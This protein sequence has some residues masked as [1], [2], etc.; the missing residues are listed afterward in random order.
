MRELGRWSEINREAEIGVLDAGLDFRLP[1]YRRAV[2]KRFYDFHTRYRSHPGGVYYLMPEIS[3]RA[4]FTEE[5]KLWFAFINGNTQNPVTSWIIFNQ[6]PN[7]SKAGDILGWFNKEWHRLQFDTDRRYQK[8]LFPMSS[9]KYMHL[10]RGNQEEYFH[11]LYA[12]ATGKA[13]FN[14][15]WQT[16]T[17]KFLGFGRLAAYSYTE[18]L[19]VMGLPVECDSLMLWDM[20]GS[21]SHRNG[22][23][24]VLGRDDLDWHASN[25][26]FNGEYGNDLL[27]W[28]ESEADVL[29]SEC[30]SFSKT[31]EN[32][33]VHEM[34]YH[35]F[36]S[37]LC[38]YKSWH[39]P[40]RRYPNV[41]N[42]MLHERIVHAQY[43]WPDMDLSMFWD[44]RKDVLP[45][46]LRLEDN[47]RDCG[48]HPS[49]QN[50]YLNTGEVIMMDTEF[51]EF[52]N[53]WMAA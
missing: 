10:T 6:F 7:V 37:A 28:L 4:G 18:Y 16:V 29:L 38:T 14:P 9:E 22:L 36:E 34:G 1:E 13:A 49:K 24:I 43:L 53:N 19:V 8:K 40:N 44:I 52:K 32:P 45:K 12:R 25:P 51:P 42:D 3:R 50:H 41:Y 20:G 23:S 15:L 35:T 46:H 2:F 33:Y 21:K 48:L 30:K 27:T 5:D 47:P 17:G 39:R 31:T 26:S 11:K